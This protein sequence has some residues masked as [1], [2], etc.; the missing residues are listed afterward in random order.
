MLI[1]INMLFLVAGRG[2]GIERYVRGLL[3]GLKRIDRNN[4]YILFINRDCRDT[5]ELT[6]NFREVA[7][8]VSATFR[9]AK[10]LW[11]QTLLPLQ[12]RKHGID[13]LLSAGN[14][15][16]L[17]QSCPSAVIMYDMIPYIRPEGFTRLE[18]GTLKTL[19]R[20][21][22]GM[23]TKIIT[24]SESSKKEIVRRLNVRED[25][26][27]V[28]YAGCDEQFKPVPVSAQARQ[29]LNS[30]GLPEKYILYVASSR[31]YKNID[32]LIKAF[33]LLRENH[34]VEQS[35]VITGLA[36]RAQPA[37]EHLVSSLGLLSGVVMSGFI[38]DEIMPLLYS[39]A[40]VFVYP[41]FYEGFGLPVIEAMACGTP[42]AAS[43]ST[44]LPEAV[45]D[46]GLLFDPYNIEEMAET[47]HRIISDNALKLRLVEKGLTRA[48]EFS[49]DR[50]ALKTLEVLEGMYSRRKG[51]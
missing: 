38:A 26:V 5:F 10:I 9:P 45:G 3:K 15:S 7:S 16:P 27:T 43:N 23:S 6:D 11:E 28:A 48:K 50:T 36:G 29:A 30:L 34:H 22:A 14:I 44:S 31:S 40:E 24:I 17:I 21:S 42:V 13:V 46:A 49:W 32:G 19:F 41:S 12:I 2:G 39:A 25:K 4:E 1:G 18:L 47:L 35:L 51:T 33:K 8:S 37:L 20:V